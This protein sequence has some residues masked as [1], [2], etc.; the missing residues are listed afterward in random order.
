MLRNCIRFEV[1]SSREDNIYRME[2]KIEEA[3]DQHT[4]KLFH[5]KTSISP[6]QNG[7]EMVD[8]MYVS[9][10]FERYEDMERF[11]KH[12]MIMAKLSQ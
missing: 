12:F 3:M 2:L 9:L 1:V 11:Q 5:M 7:S 8:L 4:T 10:Y 6:V